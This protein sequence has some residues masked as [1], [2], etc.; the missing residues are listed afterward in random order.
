M[1]PAAFVRRKQRP[2]GAT[3][4][5]EADEAMVTALSD[6]PEI[7]G[8]TNQA[9]YM[10]GVATQAIRRFVPAGSSLFAVYARV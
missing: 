1:V 2:S 3:V 5:T 8:A 7:N 9:L 10:T 4:M 6:I